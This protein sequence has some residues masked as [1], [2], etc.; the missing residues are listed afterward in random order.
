M[1]RLRP[2][3]TLQFTREGKYFV[4]ITVGIGLAAVNTGNNLLYLVF[5]MMLSLIIASGVLSEMSLRGLVVTRLPPGQVYAGSPYLTGLSLRNGKQRLPSFSIEAEDL[6]E[7]RPIGKR[8]Y[9]LKL[10]AGRTQ[11]TAYRHQ[12]ARRGLLR[13]T[14]VRLSTKFPFGLFRKSRVLDLGEALVVFPELR[15]VVPP[16]LA[17]DDRG[18]EQA[19]PERGRGGDFHGLRSYREGDDLRDIHW[20]TSARRGRP[21]V[22]EYD[23][24]AARRVTLLLDNGAPGG[25]ACQ[26]AAALEGLERA[27]SVAAWLARHYVE[28]GFLVRLL[29]RGN[30]G[31]AAGA[32]SWIVS[33]R[34]L[35]LL[36]R[37]LALLPAVDEAA[38]FGRGPG[39]GGPGP[40][41]GETVLITRQGASLSAAQLPPGERVVV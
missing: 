13:L 26:D 19:R 5:G 10:P 3:R 21:M 2:P 30:A 40:G 23:Q 9:F 1:A 38:P 4:G 35:P 11:R 37:Q 41:A 28:R 27:V 20:R 32:S 15:R 18:G 16:S 22:R 17:R 25:A 33:P 24:E 12:V 36:F 31:A 39:L 6:V 34:Q 7:G 14:G 29:T 8:C